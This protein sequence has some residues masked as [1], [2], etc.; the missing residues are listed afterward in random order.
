MRKVIE[1]SRSLCGMLRVFVVLAAM[2]V[3]FVTDVSAQGTVKGRVFDGDGSPLPGANVVVK[4]STLGTISD[5]DGNYSLSGIPSGSQTVSA[6]FIGFQA[7]E[8]QLSI[9]DG[10][11]ISQNFT[12]KEDN[13]QLEEVVVIGYGVQKK[14]L[15]T[16]A[17][18]QVSGDDIDRMKSTNALQALQGQTAGVNI[19]STSGQPG[20]GMKVSVRGVGSLNGS[21]PL[22]IVDGVQMGD[23]SY[24][25]NS[26]IES[27]DILKDA[28][29][30]AIYGSQ[31]SNGVVLITTKSGKK[32]H[33]Q[34]YFDAYYGV[35]QLAKEYELLGSTDYAMI[36]NEQQINS[37]T[38][39]TKVRWPNLSELPSYVASGTA[40]TNWLDEMFVTDAT[41]QNY[42]VGATGGN[43]ISTYAISMGYMD[44]EGIVGG[45]DES[46]YERYNARINSEHNLY[47]GI[48]KVGEHF[49]Y[50]HVKKN[51]IQVGN[52]Y[53]NTLRA[54]FNTSPLLPMYD[55]EGNYFN[56]NSKA[57]YNG[58]KY[59]YT[60]EANP[61]ASMVYG[62]Q[63]KTKTSSMVGDIYFVVEPIKNLKWRTS[64]GLDH[65]SQEYRSFAP[66]YELSDFT[67]N[68][69]TSV[70][71]SQYRNTTFSVDNTLSYGWTL[72]ENHK[73]DVMGG[74]WL[75]TSDYTYLS[76]HNTDLAYDTFKYAYISNAQS[77]NTSGTMSMSGGPSQVR[78]LSYFGRLQYNFKETY[79]FNATFRADGSSRF[80]EDNR[81]GYFPSVSAGWVISNESFMQDQS[82]VDFL[83][84]RASWGQ[85]G[86]QSISDF[87]YL[88]T[89]A[90]VNAYYP[91]GDTSNGYGN[92]DNS[93]GAYPQRLSNPDLKWETSEQLDFG[94][95]ARFLHSTLT[96]N[97]DWYKKSTKDWLIIAPIVATAGAD[98]PYINGGNV[99]NTGVELGITYQNHAGKFNYTVNLNGSYNK[100]DVTEIPTEDGVIH[101]STNQLYDNSKE[102]YRCESGHAIGYFWGYETAG[103]FQN[104][105]QIDAWKAAGNGIYQAKVAPGDIIYVDQNKDGVIDDYDKVDLGDPNPDFTFGLTFSC[106]YKAWDFMLS[107]NGVAGNQIVQSYRNLTNQN[108]NYGT[109]VLDRWHGEGTSNSIPRVLTDNSSNYQFSDLFI[110][111]GSFLRLSNIT[112]GYDLCKQIK[113]K[114]FSQMRFYASIQNLYTITGYDGM[115]PEVGYGISG[116]VTDNFSSGIDLGFYPRPR[117]YMFG[118]SLKL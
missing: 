14:K 58:E 78:M 13:E 57:T 12:L 114:G 42:T 52:Q 23:I 21:T 91:F 33:S 83:K 98:A 103:V 64:V 69:T 118:I 76:A 112:L 39:V 32:G 70:N 81:W 79:M 19:T 54:A 66:L 86:N 37:G 100:N 28:A 93:N 80:T 59:W 16:G 4:G 53:S 96:V 94:L 7:M 25:N 48:L 89:I 2:M 85:V 1:S 88:A 10:A 11:T 113:V 107:A 31:A 109:W 106:D 40:N 60:S 27:I 92:T 17:N 110:Q 74:M 51:G 41:V 5:I 55:D 65:S 82:V 36:M 56:T 75:Q 68:T 6:S 26:D 104:Q 47:D 105:A 73:F 95:D 24:L 38:P 15:V 111:D 20:E 22:Y 43:D 115:D 50:S 72:A 84:F 71:Q 9:A 99:N 3:A 117:T 67:Y 63:N 87:Q 29:S 45:R 30:A 34:V 8:V 35:Q 90:F 108:S 62:N 116:G 44:Q 49:S 97:V 46:N 77:D 61:Y 101:G 18:V 102:F